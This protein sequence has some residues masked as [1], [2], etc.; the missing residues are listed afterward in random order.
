MKTDHRPEL[1]AVSEDI[2]TLWVKRDPEL[3]EI[4]ENIPK[5]EIKIGVRSGLYSLLTPLDRLQFC[6][7][8]TRL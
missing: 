3:L 1:R 6:I 7:G 4:L 5:L 2:R 8:L